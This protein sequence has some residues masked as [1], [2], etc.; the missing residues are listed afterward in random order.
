MGRKP[1]KRKKPK[2]GPTPPKRAR[3]KPTIARAKPAPPPK[4]PKPVYPE[5]INLKGIDPGPACGY[6]ALTPRIGKRCPNDVDAFECLD[7]GYEWLM[8]LTQKNER[9]V[10]PVD[11]CPNC[12]GSY[13][14]WLS[15]D[16]P[17]ADVALSH[18]VGQAR[19]Q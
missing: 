12:G 13:W 14:E 8:A 6:A 1:K 19:C 18:R 9:W 7:C 2:R 10:W 16:M 15:Y 4:P 3:P 11:E 17:V 5:Q